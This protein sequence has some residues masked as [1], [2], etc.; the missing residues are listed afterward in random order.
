M[1]RAAWKRQ[2]RMI[3]VYHELKQQA[4]ERLRPAQAAVDELEAKA[5]G[6][7]RDLENLR[8]GQAAPAP[9]LNALKARGQRAVALGRVVEVKPE[10]EKWWP[11]LEALLGRH[12]QAI[13]PEDFKPRGRWRR[14]RQAPRKC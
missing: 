5:Q 11:L 8:E 3:G 9:L 4:E 14:S 2:G 1:K 6:L 10:A 7:R 12:R 13:L